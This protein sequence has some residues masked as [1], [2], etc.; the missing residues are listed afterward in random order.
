[1]CTSERVVDSDHLIP[2]NSFPDCIVDFA[3]QVANRHRLYYFVIASS[4]FVSTTWIS[5]TTFI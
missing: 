1:M 3:S 4:I 5:F 2:I